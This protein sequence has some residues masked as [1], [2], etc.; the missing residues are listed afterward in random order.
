[1][2]QC[3]FTSLDV[4]KDMLKGHILNKLWKLMMPL[5]L[6]FTCYMSLFIIFIPNAKQFPYFE[7]LIV[8][9]QVLTVEQWFQLGGLVKGHSSGVALNKG[10]SAWPFEP[11]PSQ[12]LEPV[13]S[14]KGGWCQ[15]VG[16]FDAVPVSAATADKAPSLC[17]WLAEPPPQDSG[18]LAHRPNTVRP[19]CISWLPTCISCGCGSRQAFPGTPPSGIHRQGRY[20]GRWRWHWWTQKFHRGPGA[21][22]AAEKAW[23]L[24]DSISKA[25]CLKTFNTSDICC[26]YTIH[27]SLF[28]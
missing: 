20:L 7:A 10:S 2:S 6:Q 14:C 22:H 28:L 18:T 24:S 21:T 8:L 17:L 15:G 3:L 25:L 19:N 13:A 16:T 9:Q 23:V 5:C 26:G 27:V 12:I 4:L 1:M 11:R